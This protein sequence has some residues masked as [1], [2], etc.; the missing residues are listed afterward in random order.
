[1]TPSLRSLLAKATKYP[2]AMSV[3]RV[4]DEYAAERKEA[5]EEIAHRLSPAVMEQVLTTIERDQLAF[6]ILE[7]SLGEQQ[8]M[9]PLPEA[10]RAVFQRAVRGRHA[11]ATKTISILNGTTQP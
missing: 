7:Q 10:W 9:P 4:A 1:M 3:N 8:G 11:E 5:R 6:D 2:P